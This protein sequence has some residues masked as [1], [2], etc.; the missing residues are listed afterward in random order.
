MTREEELAALEE[1]STATATA[2]ST[3]AR[4]EIRVM[5]DSLSTR[6]HKDKEEFE[7]IGEIGCSVHFS[8]NDK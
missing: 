7:N 3:T 6:V 2:G 8:V 4:D 1:I 5:S